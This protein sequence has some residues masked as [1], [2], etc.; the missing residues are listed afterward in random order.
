MN[1][2][3]QH[4]VDIE[5]LCEKHLVQSLFVFGSVVSER[6]SAESDID[7]LVEF[8]RVDYQG[9]FEQFMGLKD[10]L[11]GLLER[12]VDL[13]VNRKFRN[14]YFERAVQH[15]KQLVYAA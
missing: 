12:P 15:S 1:L 11:E 9:A 3:E 4:Q 8:Q 7:F 10:D 2:I 14:P 5:A 6:F 13:I